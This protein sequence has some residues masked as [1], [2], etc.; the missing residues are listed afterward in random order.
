M[1]FKAKYISYR[2]TGWFSKIVTDYL[3]NAS[4][5]QQFYNAPATIEGIKKTI[6]ARKK[7]KTNRAMLVSELQKQYRTIR[8]SEKVLENIISLLNEDTFTVCTAHQPNIFTGHLYFIYKIIHAIKL[9][10]ELKLLVP[11][12]NFVPVYYMGSEDADLEELG[13]ITINGK[14]YEWQTKQNGAVGRMKIDKAFIK[15]IEEIEGQLSVE[16]FG[17]EIIAL[18]K[19]TYALDKTIEQSTFEFVDEL[20]AGYGLLVLLPDNAALKNEFNAVNKKELTEQFSHKLVA[21]TIEQFPAEYKIQ[22]AGRDINLFYLKDDI[23]ERINKEDSKFNVN[24]SNIEFSEDEIMKELETHPERFSPNVILR[25][26]FQELVLPNI[27]FI[28]GGG[29]LAYWLELKNVFE[30]VKVPFPVL[31]LRNSFMVVPNKAAGKMAALQLDAT[32]FFKPENILIEDLVKKE[33]AVS[34]NLEDEKQSLVTLYHNIKVAATIVDNTLQ[35]HVEALETQALK[36][37]EKLER[38]M[39]KAE[40]KRFEAQQRQVHKIKEMLFPSGILQ[41]RVD[42]LLP[43]YSLWGKDLIKMLYENSTG[44]GQAFCIVEEI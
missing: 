39:L 19:K 42:N 22:A 44:L 11:D 1:S 30:A 2:Q 40:K 6:T 4:A 27:A 16:K 43:Y 17:K 9:A 23:R 12:C 32:E 8:S 35:Q 31:V 3:D 5:L 38:K 7:Y 34:L 18:V 24:N 21:E 37:I 15:L 26:V 10:E 36:R 20:F 25:P 29:E 13:E 14:K 41:E 33:S 28:G